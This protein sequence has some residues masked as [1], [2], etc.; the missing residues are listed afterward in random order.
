MTGLD[1]NKDVLITLGMELSRIGAAIEGMD[2]KE[3]FRVG[4]DDLK[5]TATAAV[6]A[7]ASDQVKSALTSVASRINAMGGAAI[8]CSMNNEEADK[9]FAG[10]LGNLGEGVYS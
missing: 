6:S 7:A 4:V 10:L 5:G 9:A 8:R 3:P 2:T 1:V